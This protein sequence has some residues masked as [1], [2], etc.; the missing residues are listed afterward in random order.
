MSQWWLIARS[1]GQVF[2]WPAWL[3]GSP[4]D[5]TL[6]NTARVAAGFPADEKWPDGFDLQLT[7]GEPH[8]SILGA[9]AP[10]D[11]AKVDPAA[12]AAHAAARAKA[13]QTQLLAAAQAAY[14]LLDAVDR[15]KV[16]AEATPVPVATAEAD[17][18]IVEVA[19]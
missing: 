8:P 7:L 14:D 9:A 10:A 1:P 13:A 18:S 4:P 3:D 5:E 12:V 19:K 16:V 15:A 11:L 2:C 6:I 17:V